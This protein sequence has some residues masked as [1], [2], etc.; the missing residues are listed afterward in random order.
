VRNV[1]AR[2]EDVLVDRF[3]QRL[4]ERVHYCSRN[5]DDHIAH[6]SGADGTDDLSDEQLKREACRVLGHLSDPAALLAVVADMEKAVIVRETEGGDTTRRA[7]LDRTVAEALA[8]NGWIACEDA[9]KILKYRITSLG[10]T[11][12]GKLMAEAEMKAL[13][14][15][16]EQAAFGFDAQSARTGFGQRGAR[17]Q[18]AE[19]PLA[20]LS[21]RRDRDGRLFLTNDLVTVGERMHEDFVLTGLSARRDETWDQ[22]LCRAQSEAPAAPQ[23]ARAQ[24]RL[25]SA[26]RDLGPG[27]GD[28]VLRCCCCLEGLELTEKR[29]GWSARSGKIVLRIA[30]QRLKRH[31]AAL[32]EE[33]ALVG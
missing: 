24:N 26:L 11:T 22:F 27:L 13:G 33:G 7:T 19:T 17:L 8:F 14:M 28:A 18:V 6:S 4:G 29:M 20:L 2:R 16:E 1:E 31:Y 3:L 15:A 21:R 32:G 23:A 10:R 9:G 30:L 25:V 12:L 5:S